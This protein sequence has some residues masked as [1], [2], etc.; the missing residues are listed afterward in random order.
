MEGK[1]K[2]RD[3]T[4]KKRKC[5]GLKYMTRNRERGIN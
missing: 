1:L 4:E 2:E 5:K 3:R